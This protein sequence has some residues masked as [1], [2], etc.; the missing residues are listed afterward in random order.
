MD[1]FSN[2]KSP[3]FY[4][5]RPEISEGKTNMFLKKNQNLKINKSQIN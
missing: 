3:H 5:K 2:F 4:Q 1:I